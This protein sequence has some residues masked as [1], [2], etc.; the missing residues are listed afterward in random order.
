MIDR[1]KVKK[2]LEL[3]ER[4]RMALLELDFQGWILEQLHPI[5]IAEIAGVRQLDATPVSRRE[6]R[7]S[8]GRDAGAGVTRF[9][10]V[11]LVNGSTV[12]ID[13]PSQYPDEIVFGRKRG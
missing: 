6:Y 3:N 1:S 12:V 7:K 13:W 10:D 5:E 2:L 9:L 11:K 4:Q 8:R